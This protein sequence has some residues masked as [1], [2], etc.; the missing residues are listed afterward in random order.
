[1]LIRKEDAAGQEEE[2]DANAEELE[3]N[4]RREREKKRDLIKTTSLRDSS[5][6]PSAL[7]ARFASTVEPL[8][9]LVQ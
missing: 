7:K 5:S 3:Q 6:S 1:M 9:S 2:E 8:N 4:R